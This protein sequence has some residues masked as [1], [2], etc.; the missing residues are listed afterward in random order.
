MGLP[1]NSF[2]NGGSEFTLER[3]LPLVRFGVDLVRFSVEFERVWRVLVFRERE[4]W[5][6]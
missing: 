3:K 4:R 2:N 1:F 5:F 6:G